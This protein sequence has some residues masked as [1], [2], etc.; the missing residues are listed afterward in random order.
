MFDLR[1]MRAAHTSFASQTAYSPTTRFTQ[2]A[3]D[4]AKID[5]AELDRHLL[6]SR[7]RTPCVA[8]MSHCVLRKIGTRHT[9]QLILALHTELAENIRDM[10]PNCLDAYL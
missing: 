10:R 6:N 9:D 4:S 5:V 1:K 2:T 8:T 3:N 7:Y